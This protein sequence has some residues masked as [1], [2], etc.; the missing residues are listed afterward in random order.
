MTADYLK[1]AD[2]LGSINSNGYRVITVPKGTPGAPSYRVVLEHRY[3]MQKWLGRPLLAQETVHHRDG[4]RLNNKIE[5]LELRSGRHGQEINI[6]DGIE[7]AVAWILSYGDLDLAELAV[8]KRL[9]ARVDA[10][11]KKKAA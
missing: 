6:I 2:G 8:C 7:A 4:N 5:N 10:H 11:K 1:A 3:V 9:Q